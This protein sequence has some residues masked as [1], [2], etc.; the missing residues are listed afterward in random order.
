MSG[1]EFDHLDREIDVFCRYL[2]G[3]SPDEY[4]TSSYRRAHDA[5]ALGLAEHGTCFDELLLRSARI[6]PPFTRLADAYTSVY[7]GRRLRSKL[8]LSLGILE[9]SPSHS[10]SVHY[11]PGRSQ[12]KFFVGACAMVFIYAAHVLAATLIFLPFRVACRLLGDDRLSSP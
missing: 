7:Q 11:P 8:V 2:I 5:G 1:P 10:A 6:S 4:V 3:Q 9:N 12:S